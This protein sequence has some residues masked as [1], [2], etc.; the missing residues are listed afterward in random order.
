VAP[1][2]RF[3]KQVAW[4][5]TIAVL[6]IG[7]S[8]AAGPTVGSGGGSQAP[9]AVQRTLVM[10]V[11]TEGESIAG[12][13]LTNPGTNIIP[14]G[15]FNAGLAIRDR[16]EVP[17]PYQA[18]SLPQLNTDSWRVSPDGRMETTYRLK[19]NLTWH[20]RT[21]LTAHD[22]AFAF[23]VYS[24]P[25]VS[26]SA[27]ASPMNKIEEVVGLD[28]R[29]VVIRWKQPFAEAGELVAADLQAL[30][31]H[32]LEQ[33]FEQLASEQFVAHPYWTLEY[34]GSGPFRVVRWDRN[35]AL[36]AEA[37][38]GHVLGRPKI[39]RLRVVP[40]PDPNVVLANMLAGETHIA[41][42]N[43]MP[44]QQ[45]W[46][47]K[48][49]WDQRGGGV[50][51][52]NPGG[53]RRTEKQVHPERANPRFMMDVR[54]RRAIAHSMDRQAVNDAIFEGTGIDAHTLLSP[55]VSYF[56]DV[57]RV[58]T[59]YSYDLRRSE[60]LMNEASLFKGPDGLYA[61]PGGERL[62]WEILCLSGPQN[63]SIQA[64]LADGWKRAGFNI[65][66]S[67]F[68][69]AQVSD[70]EARARFSTM[71]TT[72]GGSLDGM[73]TAG[74]PTAQNRW[75]GSNRGSWSNAEY[76]R[77]V[78]SWEASLDRNERNRRMVEMAKLYSEELGSTPLFYHL[79]VTPHAAG[80]RG[81]TDGVYDIHQWFWAS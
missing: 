18:E 77:L 4:W 14:A 42:A 21:P 47:L 19:P 32:I 8:P 13:S 38:D 60:Q 41:V 5:A 52:I 67:I 12:K 11:R 16:S 57:D 59:K 51:P 63:E 33:P 35:V 49:E 72:D 75:S 46:V 9:A 30:P 6:L 66:K 7:C 81:V 29:T 74:I 64:V 68:P 48:R 50:V 25:E 23:R 65:T 79:T 55:N 70:R 26:Y 17:H 43:A 58:L 71:F 15:P 56:A 61:V 27:I 78:A 37:F 10:V 31:R 2:S 54:V 39:D 76:D 34:V 44:F 40:I 36:E 20:D 53:A 3:G 22:Y 80:L 73:N 1:V 45:G 62:D 69:V 28:D 24:V